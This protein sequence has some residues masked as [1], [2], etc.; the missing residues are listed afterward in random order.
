M[1]SKQCMLYCDVVFLTLEHSEV[2]CRRRAIC[3]AVLLPTASYF[4]A[5]IVK[6]RSSESNS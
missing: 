3:S 4:D 6:L 1:G 2:A 5:P